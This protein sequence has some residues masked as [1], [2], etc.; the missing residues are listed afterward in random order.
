MI[1]RILVYT[2]GDQS[3]S[4]TIGAAARL[5]EK[6]N[7]KLI[8]LFVKPDFAG[9]TSV[10]GNF[11]LNLSQ[12]FHDLQ[13]DFAA[14]VKADFDQIVAKFDLRSQWHEVDQYEATPKPSN[15]ADLIFVSQPYKESSVVFNDTDF[16]DF[17]IMDSGLP[18]IVVPRSWSGDQLGLRPT[19]GWKECREAVGA[20]RHALPLL[21]DAED[22]DIVTVTKK[23]N[24]DDELVEGIEISEYLTDHDITTRFFAER[25]DK[26][27]HS[28]ADT[29]LRHVNDRGR[30]LIVIGGYG[31]SRFREIILGGMTRSLIK[32]STVPVLMCH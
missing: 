14:K 3:H 25:M 4:V 11:P 1:K 31:H 27:D 15:Y 2:Y 29:L 18:T 6:Y 7:A 10:Y 12:S 22:V 30:D 9:Y 5:A 17:L 19:L 8:G 32:E 21:C 26:D 28:A 13:N 24:L 16:V 20:V 23:T